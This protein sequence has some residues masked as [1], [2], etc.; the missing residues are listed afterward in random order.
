MSGL[1]LG[2]IG[3]GAVSALLNR[4]G[5]IIWMCNPCFDGDPVFCSLLSGDPDDPSPDGSFRIALEGHERSDQ[6]YLKNTA[7]L[8]TELRARD[9]SALEIL[10]F[11]PRFEHYGRNFHP[12]TLIRLIRPLSGDPRISIHLR[13]MQE[14]GAKRCGTTRGGSHVRYVGSPGGVLRVTTNAPITGVVEE[15][16]MV[17]DR[18]IALVMTADESLR[19]APLDVA[20]RFLQETSDYWHR[21][22]RSL[23]IPFEW[24]TAVIRAAITLKLSVYEDTGAIIAAP[25]TSLPEAAHTERNWDYRL[26]WLRDSFFVVRAL[27]RLS[28]TTAMEEYL[29]YITNLVA[30]M[31]G[32]MLQ[33]VYAINGDDRLVEREVDSL[34]GFRGMGPVRVGNQAYMQIQHDVYGAVVLALA[35]L[36]F[37]ARIASVHTDALLP[38]LEHVGELAIRCFGQPDA[39]IWEFRGSSEVHTYSSLM[40][41]AACD[42]LA[43]IA[44]HLDD[45]DV[46]LRWRGEADRMHQV[47]LDSAW[48]EKLNS[49]TATFQGESLDASLLLMFELDFLPPDDPRM[50]GMLAAIERDLLVDGFVYRYLEAD[51]FGE[52]QNAFLVCTFWLVDALAISGRREEARELYD[53]L[54]SCRNSLGLMAEHIDPRTGEMWGNFPQTYSMVGIINCAQRLSKR[55]EDAF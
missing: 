29:R 32:G 42:R 11:C 44:A 14:Y 16:P 5:D 20:R 18:D 30:G 55:W 37:D 25:T 52:P 45:S 35:Q 13:P 24:Q 10:D 3:N 21:W 31:D 40:C 17:L 48:S 33:P 43:R 4:R 38:R 2:L 51:D 6:D 47:L 19:Q 22:V 41:W 54:L 36:P 46:S 7:V 8:R 23:S 34:P 49:F 27:N 1:D 12:N 15:R 39:G 26:C 9:G 53:R 28:A 50:Q